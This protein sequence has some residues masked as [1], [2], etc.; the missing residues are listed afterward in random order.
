MVTERMDLLE[1][2]RKGG[3]DGDV[4]F[5]REVLRVRV[6]GGWAREGARRALLLHAEG[7]R[8]GAVSASPSW[9]KESPRH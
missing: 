4:D 6:E 9:A 2:L 7:G 3:M 1:L 8:C 5:L